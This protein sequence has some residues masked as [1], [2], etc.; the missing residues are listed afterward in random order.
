MSRRT[1][2]ELEGENEELRS[3][4]EDAYALIGEALGYEGDEDDGEEDDS[5]GDGDDR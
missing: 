4:L 2:R 1:V 3:K 5:G